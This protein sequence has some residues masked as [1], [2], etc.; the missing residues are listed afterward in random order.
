MQDRRV[1]KWGLKLPRDAVGQTRS[2]STGSSVP[3]LCGAAS[4]S[5]RAAGVASH[6]YRRGSTSRRR[7]PPSGSGRRGP[8]RSR[9]RSPTTTS[10]KEQTCVFNSS[11]CGTL[12][13][14]ARSCQ[15]LHSGFAR[16]PAARY[17]E[18]GLDETARQMVEFLELR[19]HLPLPPQ[20]APSAPGVQLLPPD[21]RDRRTDAV[22][23]RERHPACPT[24]RPPRGPSST[25]AKPLHELTTL[26]SAERRIA[27]RFSFHSES[28]RS[29]LSRWS[30]RSA[31]CSYSFD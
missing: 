7:A 11:R 21:G 20:R 13:Q 25:N 24:P 8:K 5:A 1:G 3:S 15:L 6:A 22:Q 4:S 18:K 2:A 19:V 28:S 12:L 29:R 23:P 16:R 27:L 10:R 9:S 31:S 30:D 26:A 14:S 17:P